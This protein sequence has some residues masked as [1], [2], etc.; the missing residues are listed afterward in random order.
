MQL[1]R[2]GAISTKKK[3]KRHGAKGS[4]YH[5]QPTIEKDTNN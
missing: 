1:E 5:H 2:Q 4:F 3:K